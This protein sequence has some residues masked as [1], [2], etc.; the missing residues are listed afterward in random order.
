MEDSDIYR[1]GEVTAK[2]A[3]RALRKADQLG[4]DQNRGQFV[5]MVEDALM[6]IPEALRG[7]YVKD[8]LANEAKHPYGRRAG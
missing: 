6:L 5:K 8:F 4:A 7:D 1:L 2:A 3:Q